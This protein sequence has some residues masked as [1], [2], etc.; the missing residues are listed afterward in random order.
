LLG[1]EIILESGA[2]NQS[3]SVA[4]YERGDPSHTVEG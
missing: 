3:S 1:D 4:R 2:G